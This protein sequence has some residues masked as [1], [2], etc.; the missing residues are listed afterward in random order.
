[1]VTAMSDIKLKPTTNVYLHLSE[2][3]DRALGKPVYYPGD[4]RQ[5]PFSAIL[6]YYWLGVE[7]SE[8]VCDG[9]YLDDRVD[10]IQE[11]LSGCMFATFLELADLFQEPV[12]RG[13]DTMSDDIKRDVA[14][15]IVT[16]LN[17]HVPR[18]GNGL[19]RYVSPLSDLMDFYWFDNV[20]IVNMFSCAHA[21][22]GWMVYAYYNCD[23]FLELADLFLVEEE[24]DN[25]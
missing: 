9:D 15:R 1:M 5:S 7:P 3:L 22:P 23:W 17:E 21:K 19:V 13:G 18:I 25:E 14:V 16:A 4:F 2:F 20:V 8:L 12:L 10:S 24:E 11:F 6:T